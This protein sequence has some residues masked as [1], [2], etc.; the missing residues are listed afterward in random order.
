MKQKIGIHTILLSIVV[1]LLLAII[2]FKNP[3]QNVN[4]QA[5]GSARYVFG[6]IGSRQGNREPLYLIDTREQ[7][8][9]VYEN[10]VQ[11]EGLGLITV[12]SY[13]YDKQLEA[14]GK[15]FGTDVGKIK[16]RLLKNK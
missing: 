7:V 1:V 6:L 16:E 4:A 13:K 9:M 3:I 10:S 11:G 12:R 15:S 5:D 8:I 2:I 14:F